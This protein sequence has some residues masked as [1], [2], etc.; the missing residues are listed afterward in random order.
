M[1][2]VAALGDI[3]VKVKDCVAECEYYTNQPRVVHLP[4]GIVYEGSAKAGFHAIQ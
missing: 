4:S 2:N 1:R 3:R